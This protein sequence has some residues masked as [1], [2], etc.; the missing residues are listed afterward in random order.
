MPQHAKSPEQRVWLG[1]AGGGTLNV[2]AAIQASWLE[3]RSA[4]DELVVAVDTIRTAAPA[5]AVLRRPE[6]HQAAGQPTGPQD[7]RQENRHAMVVKALAVQRRGDVGSTSVG[8][9]DAI[10]ISIPV[11]RPLVLFQGRSTRRS[12]LYLGVRRGARSSPGFACAA[13]NEVAKNASLHP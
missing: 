2:R 4:D 9:S 7:P 5:P 1:N 10:P 12:F 8:S 3:L 13:W 11:A 6:R